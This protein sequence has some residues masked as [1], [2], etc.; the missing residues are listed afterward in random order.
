MR[1]QVQLE[2]QETDAARP[3]VEPNE[4]HLPHDDPPDPPD[5]DIDE[6]AMPRRSGRSRTKPKQYNDF[7]LY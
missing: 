3:G 6:P 1:S 4:D 7:V 5:I 2:E